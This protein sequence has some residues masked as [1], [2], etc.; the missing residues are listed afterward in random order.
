MLGSIERAQRANFTPA[1]LSSLS[2]LGKRISEIIPSVL[3]R[4]RLK[5]LSASSY[6]RAKSIF[7]LPRIYN[8]LS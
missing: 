2:F 4:N 7:G 8:N 1:F 5:Y 6:D 3:M